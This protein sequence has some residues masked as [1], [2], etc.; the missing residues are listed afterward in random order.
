MAD[1]D[2]D[3]EVLTP[4]L[5][6]KVLEPLG[7]LEELLNQTNQISAAFYDKLAAANGAAIALTVSVGLSAL[8]KHGSRFSHGFL[9][10]ALCFWFSLLAAIAHNLLLVLSAKLDKGYAELGFIRHIIATS[11]QN[12]R[13][14][15]GINADEWKQLEDLAQE[16][17]VKEQGF[18]TALK[19]RY[20]STAT[21]VGYSS[22]F[23][24]F[25]GFTLVVVG[26]WK[27]WW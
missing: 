25:L 26:A 22:V 12:F 18:K 1:D 27:L 19:G 9:S 15:P 6:A 7:A 17:L 23:L 16:K 8:P 21:W 24:S 11:M 3:A 20:E 14:S 10:V 13:L 5:E 4:E 2:H